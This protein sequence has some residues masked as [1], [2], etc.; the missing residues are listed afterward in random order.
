MNYKEIFKKRKKNIVNTGHLYARYYNEILSNIINMFE[1]K[2]L[3]DSCKTNFLELYAIEGSIATVVEVKGN[4]FS[5]R[6]TTSGNID[7]YGIGNRVIITAPGL[8][9]N[10]KITEVPILWNNSLHLP[11]MD[12]LDYTKQ[13]V[14]IDVSEG[15]QVLYSRLY[16][17]PVADDN[18]QLEQYKS[19]INN[20]VK[21]NYAPIISKRTWADYEE[22]T[23]LRTLNL[24]DNTKVD[25]L[26][27]LS[28]YRDNIM[29][30]FWNRYGQA[31]QTTNKMA[32]VLDDEI[33]SNDWIS[34]IYPLDR[35]KE[36][37]KFIEQLNKIY[38]LNASVEF[39]DPWKYKIDSMLNR[40][41]SVHTEN[42]EGDNNV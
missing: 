2:G 12:L 9:L 7:Y 31:V 14:D 15:F 25:K 5:S 38:G 33:H 13:L 35:Y 4:L 42:E 19:F 10:K 34:I 16:P 18:T 36:R 21:G 22:N 26:Q 29:K 24:T 8:S 3:P 27:Y 40:I 28:M 32:Q 23:Q 37:K 11:E 41:N 1:Y 17:V 39:S 20:L 30:R 6:C